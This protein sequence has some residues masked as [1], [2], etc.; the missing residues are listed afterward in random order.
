MTAAN[1]TKSLGG[2][3]H[4]SYGV[5][6]CPAHDDA[7]PSLTIRDGER[8]ILLKCHA[9]CPTEDVIA[10]L[11][12]MG[13]WATST[14]VRSTPPANPN[15]ISH[16]TTTAALAIW[17]AS[18]AAPGTLVSDYLKSR[19]ITIAPPR[20]IRYHPALRHA[21]TGLSLPAMV[22]AVQGLATGT[23]QSVAV[24]ALCSLGMPRQEAERRVATVK[25]TD[26]PV[27]EFVKQALRASP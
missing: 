12:Q 1:L 26:L 11:K 13:V 15:S 20:S 3:W 23:S 24:L 19:G 4:G 25:A 27:E 16:S 6:G 21:P 5:A 18:R 7:N 9:G 10:E 14:P 8:D 2:R 22:C 17:Q